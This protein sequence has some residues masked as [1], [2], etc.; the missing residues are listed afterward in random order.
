MLLLGKEQEALSFV[1]VPYQHLHP[2]RGLTILG[3]SSSLQDV[4]FAVSLRT[5]RADF[6]ITCAVLIYSE[7][8]EYELLD[9]SVL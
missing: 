7:N 4:C 8:T 2:C 6:D 3:P 5:L 9:F 1:L